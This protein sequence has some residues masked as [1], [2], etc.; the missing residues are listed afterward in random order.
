ML[1]SLILLGLAAKERL[2]ALFFIPVIASYLL[3]LPLLPFEKPPGFRWRNFLMFVAPGLILGLLFLRPYLLNLSGWFDG[4]GYANNSPFWLLAGVIYYVGLP[5]ICLGSLGAV[6]FLTEKNRAALLLLLSEIVPLMTLMAISPFH[7]TANRYMFISL[8]SWVILA[9]LATV[10]LLARCEGTI[11]LLV[12]GTLS[13]LLLQPIAEDVLY[14]RFQN[15]NRDDWKTAFELIDKEKQDGDLI[16]TA[17]PELTDFYLQEQTIDL[18]TLDLSNIKEQPYRI[19]FV[20][21]SVAQ[22]LV[23]EVPKWFAQHGR[24]IG[25]L[26]VHVQARTFVMRVYFYNPISG[27]RFL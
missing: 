9:G 15:G 8:T 6:Y 4:F 7:Y 1:L 11:K 23:P 5:M 2:L 13:F 24:L 27:S 12:L 20:E 22:Q 3:L 16:V 25:N 19:W 21:D 14:Y 10:E 26:D 18:A 17:Y